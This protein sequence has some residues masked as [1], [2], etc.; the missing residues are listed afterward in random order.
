MSL[1]V[2]AGRVGPHPLVPSHPQAACALKRYTEAVVPS[3]SAAPVGA[4]SDR[5]KAQQLKQRLKAR[6]CCGAGI[7]D[8]ISVRSKVDAVRGAQATGPETYN[9]YGDGHVVQGNNEMR[10]F[11][12]KCL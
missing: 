1:R 10:R 6:S 8:R 7:P 4:D 3:R 9:E 12:A 5:F 11:S 2:T